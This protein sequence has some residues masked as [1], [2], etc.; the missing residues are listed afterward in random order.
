MFKSIAF[1][2]LLLLF[3]GCGYNV[4]TPKERF[5][6]ANTIAKQNYLQT[7][8][9]KTKNFDIFSYSTD[10]SKCK[11]KNLHAYIEGDGL[12]WI[13]SS[14]I[15][16]DPTPINPLALKLMIQDSAKCKLY[17]ARPCQ[18]IKTSKCT[19]EVWTSH[20]FSQEVID[21]YHEIFD[22]LKYKKL[23][24]FGYSG[25]GTVATLL[26][27]QRD[28]INELVTIAGNLDINFWAKKHYITPLTGSLNPINFVSKLK[29]I[30]QIHLIG[31]K[32]DIVGIS[33]FNSYKSYFINDANIKYKIYKN[34]THSCCWT[35][36]WKNI[37]KGLKL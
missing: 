5:D 33:V 13:T 7:K 24:L 2:S 6:T 14:T 12:S 8:I 36:E 30:K 31:G 20:R 32:D 17:L 4:P 1:A 16:D 19:K 28:D 18:Y 3:I 27:A 11:Q 34:F 15:S 35:K 25:G 29:N 10:L 26:S 9:Y 37:L 22:S 23:T 21:S